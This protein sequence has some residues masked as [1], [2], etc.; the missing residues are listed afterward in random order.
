MRHPGSGGIAGVDCG[1]FSSPPACGRSL[2]LSD[3]NPRSLPFVPLAPPNPPDAERLIAHLSRHGVPMCVATS[4]TRH[5]YALKTTQHE[6]LFSA[7]QH[8][9][10]GDDVTRGK[11]AP[12]IFLAAAAAFLPAAQAGEMC[13]VFEDAPSGVEAAK[14]AGM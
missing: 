1:V 4:S 6:A 12:D 7:F 11:P 2:P 14:A 10:T 3:H 9:T 5:G 8:V 13:L